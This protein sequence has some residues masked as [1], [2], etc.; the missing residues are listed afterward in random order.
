MSPKIKWNCLKWDE[1]NFP[2]S[3]NEAIK[4]AAKILNNILEN[5]VRIKLN[6]GV[7]EAPTKRELVKN[8]LGRYNGFVSAYS[9][10]RLKYNDILQVAGLKVKHKKDKWSWLNFETATIRIKE[11]INSEYK[12]GKSVRQFLNLEPLQAPKRKQLKDLGFSEFIHALKTKNLKYSEVIKRAGLRLNK[13]SGRWNDLNFRTATHI[14][15][16][17]LNTPFRD[18]ASIRE[19]LK[20][21]TAEAPS[22]RQLRKVSFRDFILALYRKNISYIEII[23][24]LGLISHAKDLNQEIGYNLHLIIEYLFLKFTREKNCISFYEVILNKIVSGNRIDNLIIRNREFIELIE[25]K[26]ETLEIPENI[27]IVNVE[28]YSGSDIDTI[29]QKCHK[30]YQGKDRFLI[31]VLLLTENYNIPTP[32]NI[33]FKNNVK[34]FNAMEFS[35]FIGYNGPCLEKFKY[36]IEL[37]RASFYDK[38][39]RKELRKLAI[40]F[41]KL[42]KRDFNFGQE[43]FEKS[44]IKD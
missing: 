3:Y 43:E 23:E 4:N 40:D 15:L 5:K 41:K 34:I 28:Y 6:L 35:Q 20:I 36:S 8:D 12:N 25:K 32:N 18:K 29:I 2:R 9:R 24:K 17:M 39:R 14:I 19:Y 16:N 38:Q 13:E 42:I 37:A 33:P 7:S 27:K 31:I 30:N 44:F 10:N 26:Q 11:I 21:K 1:N 22:T